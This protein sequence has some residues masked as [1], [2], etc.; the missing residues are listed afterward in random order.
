[1][2]VLAGTPV[3]TG[4][5]HELCR[6]TEGRAAVLCHRTALT[7]N[8]ATAL[9]A[10]RNTEGHAAGPCHRTALTMNS[11]TALTTPQH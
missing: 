10:S 9:M 1:M 4:C 5:H 3:P 6:N 11:V 7:M 2:R 8:S